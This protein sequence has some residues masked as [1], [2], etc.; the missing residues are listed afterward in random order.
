[1]HGNVQLGLHLLRIGSLLGQ[2]PPVGHADGAEVTHV[3]LA[4]DLV[5]VSAGQ[6]FRVLLQAV[7]VPLLVSGEGNGAYLAGS[8]G[9]GMKHLEFIGGHALGHLLEAGQPLVEHYAD[10]VGREVARQQMD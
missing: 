9:H 3:Q 1:M 4:Q 5:D 6:S 7:A 2:S 10:A 8:S